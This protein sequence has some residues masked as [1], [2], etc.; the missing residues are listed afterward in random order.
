[1]CL[2]GCQGKPNAATQPVWHVPE[3]QKWATPDVWFLDFLSVSLQSQPNGGTIQGKARPQSN[4]SKTH[5]DIV[6]LLPC[7]FHLMFLFEI[8]IIRTGPR[9]RWKLDFPPTR[10]LFVQRC[11]KP[12]KETNP[13]PAFLLRLGWVPWVPWVATTSESPGS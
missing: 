10:F 8:P 12:K 1:M 11:T 4:S 9:E 3:S 7:I 5:P 13:P 2:L 6:Q